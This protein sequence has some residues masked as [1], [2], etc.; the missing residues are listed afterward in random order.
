MKVFKSWEKKWKK[1]DRI[2]KGG[3]GLT[4]FAFEKNTGST[5]AIKF[6]KEQKVI[7]RRERMFIEVS[8]LK[9]LNHPKIPKLIDSNEDKYNNKEHDLFLVSEFIPG[10]TLEE[11]ITSNGIMSLEQAI[12]F[13]TKVSLIVEHC[14]SKGII[15]RDIKPDNIILRDGD[16]LDPYLIDFGLSFNEEFSLQKSDTPS[17][18]HIGNRFL[19]LPEL[20]VSEGNKRDFRSDVTMVCGIFLFCLTG[21][22]PTDLIDEKITKPHRRNKEKNCINKLKDYKIASINNFFDIAFNQAIN[23]RWQ[24]IKSVIIIL[25]D[26]LNMKPERE[27][28]NDITK[29]LDIF[30]AKLESRLDY[31]QLNQIRLVLSKCNSIVNYSATEVINKLKPTEF[32]TIQ[33]GYN[34]DVTKQVF[35]NQFGIKT[36]FSDEV[37]FFP[38]FSCY[39]NGSEFVFESLESNKRTELSRFQ[40]YEDFDWIALQ[41]KVI[42]YYVDGITSK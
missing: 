19:S 32:E 30:K 29:K 11:F 6:L 34:L 10:P 20:R 1:G 7:D 17:W 25:N 39:S 14:H 23:E 35:T 3:Q 26:I 24:T 21:I 8:A 18:Q 38:K 36:T 41:Q 37:I 2:G 22:H 27:S 31:K 15:H 4:Y 40:L 16:L 9:I 42:E 33:T 12:D 28:E 5:Y 13:T